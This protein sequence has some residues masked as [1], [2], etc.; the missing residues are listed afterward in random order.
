MRLSDVKAVITL[1]CVNEI[2][3]SNSLDSN[4]L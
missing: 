4:S 2:L 3:D 1:D